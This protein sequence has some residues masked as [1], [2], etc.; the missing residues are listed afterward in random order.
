MH[1]ISHKTLREF[2]EAY[3]QSEIAI[4]QWYDTAKNAE[5]KCYADI[6]KDFNSVDS[7]G[8][9]RYV[10]NIKGNTFR[11]VVI[12]HFK[13]SRIYIRFIGT[14]AQYTKINCNTI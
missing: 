1:I 5:W 9:Q 2:Y 4:G 8:N 10:F 13:I 12:I 7:V 14:H 6:K 11:L 3:P